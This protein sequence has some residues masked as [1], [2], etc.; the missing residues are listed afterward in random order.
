MIE[1]ENVLCLCFASTLPTA[2]ESLEA[3]EMNKQSLC[4]DVNQIYHCSQEESELDP[5]NEAQG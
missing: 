4:D 1:L 5:K 2:F 3:S